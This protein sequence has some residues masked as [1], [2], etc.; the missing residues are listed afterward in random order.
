MVRQVRSRPLGSS[1]AL[2][3]PMRKELTKHTSKHKRKV[4]EK[5]KVQTHAYG[6]DLSHMAKAENT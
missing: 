4:K 5:V 2:G 3:T 1:V 6:T